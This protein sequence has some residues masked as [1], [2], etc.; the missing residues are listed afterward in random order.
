MSALAKT[1]AELID[2]RNAERA[3]TRRVVL[4]FVRAA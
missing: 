1:V 4:P 3:R 2:V